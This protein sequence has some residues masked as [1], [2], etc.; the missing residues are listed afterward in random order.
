MIINY[1]IN[2]KGGG[3]SAEG[4][5]RYDE[6]QDL[7]E[8]QQA[9]AKE[10]L[11]IEDPEP[12]EQADW[13]ETDTTDPAFIKNKPTIPTVNNP[14]VTINQGGVQK[15]SFTLNQANAAT[16]NLDGGG[17]ELVV[18]TT[19]SA[20]KA[21]RNAGELVPGTKYRITDYHCTTGL[22]GTECANHQ[23]DI[24]VKAVSNNQLSHKA[25]AVKH[26]FADGE[27]NDEKRYKVVFEDDEE[28]GLL[29]L[30]G[31]ATL[32]RT[33]R[34]DKEGDY[35]Y[36]FLLCY[37]NDCFT[38]NAR[39]GI[40]YAQDA[41]LS[42]GYTSFEEN[43]LYYGHCKVT[44]VLDYYGTSDLSK[45][46]LG[47]SIDE[48]YG[49]RIGHGYLSGAVAGRSILFDAI[50]SERKA[51]KVIATF[52]GETVV[53][54]DATYDADNGTY[55][56]FY[57]PNFIDTDNDGTPG[58]MLIGPLED[59]HIND[60]GEH[61]GADSF[62][63]FLDMVRDRPGAT[64]RS[65]GGLFRNDVRFYSYNRVTGQKGKYGDIR[66]INYL[67]NQFAFSGQVTYMKDEHGNEA[68]YDFKNLMFRAYMSLDF[69]SLGDEYWGE[70][71]PQ[72]FAKDYNTIY[73][74]NLGTWT[75]PNPFTTDS[76]LTLYPDVID[77][78]GNERV[79]MVVPSMLL[80]TFALIQEDAEGAA[81]ILPVDASALGRARNNTLENSTHV[82]VYGN[83]CHIANS[84]YGIVRGDNNTI[85]DS[86]LFVVRGVYDKTGGNVVKA[87]TKRLFLSG[88]QNVVV[89]I[90]DDVSLYGNYNLSVG[91]TSGEEPPFVGDNHIL[92][93]ETI[94]E[95]P[96]DNKQYARCNGEWE[97]VEAGGGEA[98]QSDW[99]ETDTDDPAFIC[100]KPTIPTVNNPTVTINQGGTTKGTFT[101][102]QSGAATINL[103]GGGSA[104]NHQLLKSALSEPIGCSANTWAT[105][106]ELTVPEDG[107]YQVSAS[108]RMLPADQ[109]TAFKTATVSIELGTDAAG[110]TE[111]M[112]MTLPRS[113]EYGTLSVPVNASNGQKLRLRAISEA[114]FYAQASPS[115]GKASAT[116]IAAVRV[117]A[118]YQAQ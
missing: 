114:N 109:S 53:V 25:S 78:E 17:S 10:N 69:N 2:N 31:Y 103:D 37:E 18:E 38:D 4:C 1:D 16:I 87:S 12:Q 113:G 64:E 5:L 97:E 29:L 117:G 115:A 84:N 54:D 62:D 8:E 95:A 49:H 104:E 99:N 47:F 22:G 61:I 7:T 35:P 100:N 90:F 101:L 46:E 48:V 63:E 106:A 30:G 21:L 36:A 82:I 44:D 67:A 15:G 118:I 75:E 56:L 57:D 83:E 58:Y 79:S 40:I 26:V 19:Y 88:K 81:K 112:E 89:G 85:A 9:Q 116:F 14:T 23:F 65:I 41:A 52:T 72:D 74:T 70:P 55:G 80:P 32:T 24:V 50:Q 96:S 39:T 33:P 43:P 93:L 92:G 3:A 28:E 107:A 20:L 105:L 45:W 6:A 102:N 27:D 98:V 71:Y 108:A 34:L 11:G 60:G 66:Y 110:Y 111:V 77:D 13:N 73:G 59:V 76:E 68:N 91:Y 42:T 51:A 86:Q 94:P